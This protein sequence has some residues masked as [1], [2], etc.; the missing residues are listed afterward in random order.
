MDE[1]TGY[2]DKFSVHPGDKIKFFVNCDGPAEYQAEI[3][4]MIHADTNPRG[5]GFIE[6]SIKASCNGSYKGMQAGDLQRLLWFRGRQAAVLRGKRHAAVLDLADHA[7][8]ASEILETRRAGPG[9]QV[10]QRQGIRPLHQRGR[11]RRTA[12]QRP[13]HHHRRAA[14]RPCLAFRGGELRRQDRRGRPLSR[15]ADRLRARSGDRAG[16]EEAR[17]QARLYA[18][19]ADGDRGVYAAR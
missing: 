13:G 2:A 16:Q 14:A 4:K 12:R 15:A 9:H 3:V 19:H 1:I 7:E 17:H 10:A 11:M 18:G 5:P 8:D 6:K